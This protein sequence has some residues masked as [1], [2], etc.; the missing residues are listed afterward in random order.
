PVA[1]VDSNPGNPVIGDR[2]F[3]SDPRLVVRHARAVMDAFAAAGIVSCIKHY[4]GHGDTSVDSHLA[5]PTVEADSV[6]LRQVELYPFERLAPWA[7]AAMS[8]HVRFPALDAAPATFSPRLLTT[9]LKREFLFRGV[10]F[11]DDLEMGAL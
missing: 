6:R 3:G 8:A 1:D 2:A 10:L 11:S 9:L 7:S 5:L 4:P